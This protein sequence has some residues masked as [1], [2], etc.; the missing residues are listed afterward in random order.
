MRLFALRIFTYFLLLLSGM[1]ARGQTPEQPL[2]DQLIEDIAASTA[3]D[4]EFNTLGDYLESLRYDPLN[5][6]TAGPE[7]LQMLQLLSDQQI[8]ALIQYR[9]WY[10]D[11]LSIYELQA[12]QH[13]DLQTVYQLAPYIE[14]T[15]SH[16]ED[17]WR[18]A[19][20]W[21]YARQQ[22]FMRF[23]QQLEPQ[24]GYTLPD[25]VDRS[26]YLGNPHRY[27]LRYQYRYSRNLSAGFTMEKDPGEPIFDSLIPGPD[28]ASAHIFLRNKGRLKA[29]ALGDYAVNMGQGLM[30]W[31]GFGFNKS[32]YPMSV[33]RNGYTIQPYTSVNEA[34]FFRGVAATYQLATKWQASAFVSRKALDGN[35][36]A[37][38]TSD[39]EGTITAITS[40]QASGYHRTANEIA[41]KNAIT[42]TVAGGEIQYQG[43]FFNIGIMAAHTDLSATL[44]P[45]EDLYRSFQFRGGQLTNAGLHYTSLFRDVMVFGE[46][47]HSLGSGWAQLHGLNYSL[48]DRTAISLVYR[49]YDRNYQSLYSQSFGETSGTNNE[50]G[51]YMGFSSSIAPKFTLAGYVDIFRFPWLRFRTDAPSHG[52]EYL[53]QLT[54]SLGWGSD[55]YLRG[56]HEI[57]YQNKTDNATPMD[58]LIA[59]RRSEV[60]IH[61]RK[62]V[63]SRIA[64]RSRAV[65]SRYQEGEEPAEHGFMI[66][67]DLQ[68]DLRKVPLSFD[69]R[70]ALFDAE[71]FDTRM[72]AYESD[73]LYSF[74]VPAYSGEGT[75]WY[76]LA[77]W[78]P[79]RHLELWVR[80]A[81]FQYP[82]LD[83][84]GSG[85]TTTQ[86]NTR[87]EI[88][89]QLRWR[90]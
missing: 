39:L 47:A 4:F 17:N 9:K 44:I 89:A 83:T 85:L 27:Y 74:S 64:I 54:Y 88:K 58:Y 14:A 70:F 41:D 36:N 52:V 20:A 48:D 21:K 33:Q 34:L 82:F 46:I 80:L 3:S 16:D 68:Y 76:V 62:E 23:Q 67:Q 71:S 7:A 25:T 15:P 84:I 50:T 13:F 73:V 10:G 30:M 32:P 42:G 86:G 26:R 24:L 2:N 81:Q 78:E 57:K 28:Y 75:R 77:N 56:R 87:T 12:V 18:L 40:I 53:G 63:N 43:R 55:V 65:Y 6:N 72:Y 38:D 49:N 90:W 59:R 61:L 66:F 37:Q 5:I 51:L 11:L 31:S 8:A 29:L 1:M 79:S 45:R 22:L 35:I 60:R 69:V 19:N